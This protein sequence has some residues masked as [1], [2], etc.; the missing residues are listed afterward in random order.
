MGKQSKTIHGWCPAFSS[1][2]PEWPFQYE[3]PLRQNLAITKIS[4]ALSAHHFYWHLNISKC[5]VLY[6]WRK[7]KQIGVL[8]YS[9]SAAH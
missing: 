4:K 2:H 3:L 9:S 6:A 5:S 1:F 8:E 7:C